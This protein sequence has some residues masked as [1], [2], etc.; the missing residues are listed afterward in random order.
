M[1]WIIFVAFFA[2]N[3]RAYWLMWHD[4]R[5]AQ[6]GQWRVSEANLLLT[7][8]LGGA[9]GIY[10]GMCAPLY[11]KAAKP[12]FKITVPLLLLLQ[13]GAAAWCAYKFWG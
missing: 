12:K 6:L 10:A 1:A 4:K 9:L 13:V 8:G 5:A 3:L 7:A 2:V 11:H